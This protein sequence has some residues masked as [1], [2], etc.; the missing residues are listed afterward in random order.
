[1]KNSGFFAFISSAHF[2]LFSKMRSWLCL[3][4]LRTSFCFSGSS[5][6]ILRFD[7]HDNENGRSCC[8]I[9]CLARKTE[10]EEAVEIGNDPRG[11]V[12]LVARHRP[13]RAAWGNRNNMTKK[14][15]KC[16]TR[17]LLIFLTP[18]S[19]PILA[20][21]RA[22][23]VEVEKGCVCCAPI[24]RSDVKRLANQS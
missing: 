21:V 17:A 23:A 2:L 12:E 13:A 5:D 6:A 1:M 10:G 9:D 18:L 24:G 4:Y 22:D 15:A 19:P 7:F 11:V 16:R 8:C 20:L 3:R 14:R